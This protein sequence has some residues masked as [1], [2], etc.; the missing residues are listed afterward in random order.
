MIQT[1]LVGLHRRSG[2]TLVE[3]LVVIAIIGVL[4]GLLLPAVQQAREAA[5][6]V[7]CQNNLHNIALGLMNYESAYF[8][9]PVGLSTAIDDDMGFDDDGFGWGTHILP[10]IEQNNLHIQL[11]QAVPIG[12]PGAIQRFYAMNGT[13]IPGGDTRISTYRCPSSVL[14]SHVQ[15]S[16]DFVN[17]YATCDYKGCSGNADDGM[18]MKIRDGA[19]Q[20]V[21]QIRLANVTD[22]LSNTICIGE[23]AYFRSINDWPVWIGAPNADEPAIFKT[24][25]PSI[26]NAGIFP[27]SVDNFA[28][29]IDDDCAFSWHSG[30]AFFNFADGSVHFLA[31][32]I[33]LQTFYNLGDREDGQAIDGSFL[34]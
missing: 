31:E 23:S 18:L 3:L 10:F 6:R 1:R 4:V 11:Q 20:G 28:F 15:G 5:R 12:T 24:S 14:N 22:G 33:D 26:I 16:A 21:F 17:G 7:S 8:Q 2:F 13:I 32:T 19:R 29:A 30:G 25:A 9:F 34:E 27:K